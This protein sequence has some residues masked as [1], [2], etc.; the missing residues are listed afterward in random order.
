MYKFISSESIQM[1]KYVLPTE[2]VCDSTWPQNK[3]SLDHGKYSPTVFSP[4][5]EPKKEMILKWLSLFLGLKGPLETTC[6]HK[7]KM[8]FPNSLKTLL[9]DST[10][11]LSPQTD[12]KVNHIPGIC[13]PTV[14][15]FFTNPQ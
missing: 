11:V 1:L 7:R 14:L 8:Y 6:R 2:L 9:H 12:P 5:V 3:D 15:S 10:I 13:F 4:L